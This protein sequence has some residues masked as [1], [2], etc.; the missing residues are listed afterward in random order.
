[1]CTILQQQ[2]KTL[3]KEINLMIYE[4]N[5]KNLFQQVKINKRDVSNLI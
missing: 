2:I 3:Y 1:M 5:I 4:Q